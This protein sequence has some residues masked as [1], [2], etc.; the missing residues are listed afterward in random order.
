MPSSGRRTVVTA[1][2]ALAMVAAAVALPLFQP[3]RLVTDPVVDEAQPD[4]GP[5]SISTSSPAPP[6][7]SGDR[8]PGIPAG[9]TPPRSPERFAR[10]ERLSHGSFVT[11]EH[12]TTG[13]VSVV[14]LADGSRIL[15]LEG[16]DSSEGPDLEVWLSDAPV[17]EGRA[18]RHLFD[19]GRYR[20]LGQLK[21]S[22][23]HQ[24]YV[25]PAG[26]DLAGFRSVSIWCNRFN[27]SFGAAALNAV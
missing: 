17:L 1:T 7:I 8:S 11:H 10:P 18:G 5:V 4:V 25:I 6:T 19:D 22:H 27:V 12:E 2:V 13:T 26:L 23:G 21:G 16:V 9:T 14:R 20:N 15:R 3:W 24:N